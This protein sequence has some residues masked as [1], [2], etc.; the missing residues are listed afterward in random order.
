MADQATLAAVKE[1]LGYTG[2]QW[3][4]FKS[5]PRN[6]KIVDN[7][8][9]FQKYK[10]VAEVT[11]SCGCAAGHKVGD[12]IVFGAD[13]TL[14]CSENPSR[15]CVGLIAPLAPHTSGVLEKICSGEDPTRIAF[16]KVHCV[17]VGLE[18]GG[19]GEVVVEV[20]VEKV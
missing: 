1:M 12:R 7:L 14:L 15:V 6:M 4:T 19:W 13:G 20:K 2:A 9:E 8:G 17:D 5:N 11:H 18:H 3:E 10:V 16:D